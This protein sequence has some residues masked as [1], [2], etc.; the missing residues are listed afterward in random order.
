M[1]AVIKRGNAYRDQ[2]QWSKAAVHYE[3][4]LKQDPSLV[5]I[6]VQLGHML[7]EGGHPIE[8]SKAYLEALQRKPSDLS[9]LGWLYTIAGQLAPEQRRA[10][11]VDIYRVQGRE[12]PDGFTSDAAPIP[13]GQ[14]EIVFDVSDLMAYFSRSRRPTGIQRVQIEIIRAALELP[15]QAIRVCCSIEHSIHWVE[16]SAEMFCRVTNLAV[17]GDEVDDQAWFEALQDLNT[18]L[19][20]SNAFEFGSGAKIINLGT[21][22]WLQNYF[23][24]IRNAR[25]L[26]GVEYVPFVHDLIPVLAPQHCVQGLVED[27]NSWILGIFDHAESFLVNSEATKADLFKVAAMLG[28]PLS[29]NAVIVVPLDGAFALSASGSGGTPSATLR[30]VGLHQRRFV[31]FVSTIESRKGHLVALRAW[32]RLLAEHGSRTPYLVCVG[33]KGWLNSQVYELLEADPLLQE[34]VILLSGLSDSDLASLYHNCLFTI[35]PSTYEG[36][37]LPITEALNAGKLVIAAENSSLPQAG[38]PH[39]VYTRTLDDAHLAEEVAR[40]A[41]NPSALTEREGQIIAHFKARSWYDIARQILAAVTSARAEQTAPDTTRPCPQLAPG[42]W[43]DFRR[44]TDI[45]AHRQRA[46]GERLRAGTGW[47][48]PDDLGCWLQAN[49]AELRFT[50]PVGENRLLI[51]LQNRHPIDWEIRVNGKPVD[52]GSHNK[53]GEFWAICPFTAGME[54][55]VLT[56]ATLPCNQMHREPA[57]G[58]RRCLLLPQDTASLLEIAIDLAL[59]RIDAMGTQHPATSDL[60]FFSAFAQAQAPEI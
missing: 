27:F 54:P 12:I 50:A 44:A 9:S 42:I 47:S 32:Q 34:R 8:A 18:Y 11:I 30:Q 35:Y 14:N 39:A 58:I 43:L 31:L 45:K 33:S 40:Y 59:G 16:I 3:Q 29:D 2:R 1:H 41:F 10:L 28:K 51:Q 25:L 17:F 20:F 48:A 15:D 38:G 53:G 24:Q 5:H 13:P 52:A 37:G 55:V 60:P 57:L 7:K 4:A 36:W 19:I 22:W 21:S 23:L 6:W 26:S 46:L 49:G 56:I